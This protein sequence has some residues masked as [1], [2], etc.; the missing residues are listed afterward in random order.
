MIVAQWSCEVSQNKKESFLNYIKTTL[1]PF[2]ES[3]GCLRYE[4]FFPLITDKKYFPYQISENE[5]RYTEQL[6]FRDIK[7]FN[8][9]YDSIEK[10]QNAQEVVGMYIKEFGINNCNFKILIQKG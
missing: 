1:K 7:A 4:I 6:L 2:Y 9:F 5:T 8:K 10:D 3:H